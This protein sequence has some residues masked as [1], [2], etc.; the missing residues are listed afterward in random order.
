MKHHLKKY[1]SL[2]NY[3][4]FLR[5]QSVHIQ[6]IYAALFAGV[7]TCLL[8]LLILYF[9]YDLWHET[10]SRNEDS[11]QVVTPET[12]SAHSPQ[13]MMS[14]FFKEAGQKLNAID[15]SKPDILNGKET[16]MKEEGVEK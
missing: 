9:E 4:E 3:I 7:I 13:D 1:T 11:V 10:Y 15:L 8:G 14:E 5:R 6:R 2:A 16:Y 12:V